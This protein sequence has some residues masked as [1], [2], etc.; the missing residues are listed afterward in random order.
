[1]GANNIV[2]VIG[3]PGVGKDYMLACYKKEFGENYAFVNAGEELS[4]IVEKATGGNISRDKLSGV[5]AGILRQSA[6]NLLTK[7]IRSSRPTIVNTHIV[8]KRDG[9]FIWDF[10]SEKMI[11]SAAYIHIIAEPKDILARRA[12]DSGRERAIETI[13]EIIEYQNV[14]L[15]VTRNISRTLN[16]GFYFIL[17]SDRL[18]MAKLRL[19][20][21]V[22]AA[23]LRAE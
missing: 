7:I 13:D 14:S 20:H 23:Y 2:Q 17:N 21:R 10:D 19:M 18:L 3:I 16:A 15:S 22:F 12:A 4:R 8:F 9:E 5:D 6:A 11:N 1:M